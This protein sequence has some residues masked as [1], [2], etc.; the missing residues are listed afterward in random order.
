MKPPPFKYK[1]AT[2]VDEALGALA[3]GGDEAKLLAG[4]QSLIA[5]MNL[6]LVRP[7]VLVDINRVSALDYI[8]RSNGT[9]KIGAMTRQTTVEYSAVVRDACPL[10]AAALPHVAHKP[11]RNR[12]T[13]GG[14]LAHNDPT[15]ELPA[16]ALACD[17]EMVVRSAAGERTVAAADFFTG[18]LETALDDDEILTAV[19]FPATAAGSGYSF[20]EISP[21][22]GDYAL[23]GVAAL[24]QVSGGTCQDVRIVCLGAGESARRMSAAE[25]T[26]NGQ[27]PS[28]EAF[29]AA[30]DAAANAADPG[31]D[32]HASADYRRD[33]IRSLT[34]RALS[35]AHGRGR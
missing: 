1:R 14:S 6:R 8:E 33:L 23:V 3:E 29:R 31:S 22:K 19:H 10:L 30:A 35:K 15:A 25:S 12:G 20:M 34:Q 11:I 7:S 16:V 9:L 18:Y 32:Y 17:A 27:A 21:R 5:L 28:E 2:T 24:M 26:L 4:G 13:I